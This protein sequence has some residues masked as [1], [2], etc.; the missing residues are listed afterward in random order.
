M[1]G[2]DPVALEELLSDRFDMRHE[3]VI[4]DYCHVRRP[5]VSTV[6]LM[7]TRRSPSLSSGDHVL[8]HLPVN[9]R[10]PEVSPLELERQPLVVDAEE[11][12]DGCLEVVDVDG[13][14][15]GVHCQV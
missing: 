6:Y 2:L 8:H 10:Q 3:R 12:E 1:A 13:V 7:P 9:V 14:F 5:R 11:A 4:G 15:D